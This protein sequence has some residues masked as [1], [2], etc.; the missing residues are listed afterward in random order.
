MHSSAHLFA[1]HPETTFN[2]NPKD[3][4][5]PQS[6]LQVFAL[7]GDCMLQNLYVH[8]EPH[9]M[10][11]QT[12][13]AA[14]IGLKQG[15][16]ASGDTFINSFYEQYW[17][18]HTEIGAIHLKVT[19]K[20]RFTIIVQRKTPAVPDA[21]AAAQTVGRDAT[22]ETHSIEIDSPVVSEPGF[23]GRLCALFTCLSLE[24]E[25][26]DARWVTDSCPRN[27]P[28]VGL[29]MCT[30]NKPRH[31]VRN[32]ELLQP[33]FSKHSE[34]ATIY[35]IDQGLEKVSAT[36]GY[37]GLAE[38]FR[39][40]GGIKL[41][42]Q[43]NFGGAGGFTRGMLE[44]FKDPS[45]THVLFMDDDIRL[46]PASLHKLI[47][48][49]KFAK[50]DLV[51]GGEM[52][53][54]YRRTVLHAH[55]ERADYATMKV[56]GLPRHGIDVSCA[57]ALTEL[58]EPPRNSYNAWWFCSFPRS[59]VEQCGLPLPIFVRMDD[60][61]YGTR[62]TLNDYPL[63]TLP[64]V[65]VWHEP[66]DVKDTAWME[67]YGVRNWFVTGTCRGTLSLAR[68]IAAVLK[69]FW[70]HLA[71]YRF[72]HALAVILALETFSE[73]PNNIFYNARLVDGK[74]RA[75]VGALQP[76][77][78]VADGGGTQRDL[79]VLVKPMRWKL[80]VLAASCFWVLVRAR[81][82][83][84]SGDI[85]KVE[86]AHGRWFFLHGR[87]G[88]NVYNPFTQKV[89]ELRANAK[90]AR[91]LTRRMLGATW[92]AWRKRRSLEVGYRLAAR[93]VTSLEAWCDYLGL[94]VSKYMNL[95]FGRARKLP[96]RSG[97]I[98]S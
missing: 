76:A 26:L 81:N 64:G 58:I 83:R 84:F 91:R 1:T 41:I 47:N 90:L 30:Y 78:V 11:R 60:V 72:D 71:R 34:L 63:V 32:L 96:C 19:V 66:F 68:G 75:E 55:G 15:E 23:Y 6:T 5:Q 7:R 95:S 27:Q 54:L 8:L 52:L 24:G 29:V 3:L 48:F 80:A 35:V 17:R 93:R 9:V 14:S 56:I 12:F 31:V 44:T 40:S 36:P 45:N 21:S 10:R 4:E 98:D 65:F 92:I 82:R 46:E 50:H 77:I 61:E 38:K 20:G 89:T 53:D 73:G 51:V 85:A 70:L 57:S 13:P 67:Y 69:L 59:A 16:T 39:D 28:R 2:K 62:L 79:T 74:M 37:A 88:L 86:L 22:V 49:L 33:L 18:M 87:V 94:D 25:I 43:D 42:E 97:F